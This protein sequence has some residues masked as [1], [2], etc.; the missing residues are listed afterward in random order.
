MN[1]SVLNL[2][3]GVQST[4]IYLMA[5]ENRRVLD[6]RAAAALPGGEGLSPFEPLPFPA[7]GEVNFAI[8]ADTQDEPEEVYRH[9]EWLQGL[10]GVPIFVRTKGR[11]SA[12]LRNGTN[13][14]GGRFASIPAFT[15]PD[16]PMGYTGPVEEG[17]LRRQCTKEYKLE[18]IDR[19]IRREI[20]NRRPRQRVPKDF[21]VRQIIG[22]S[23]D[24]KGRATRLY[25]RIHEEGIHWLELDF[26]LLTMNMAREHCVEW[27]EPRVPHKCPRSACVFCPFHDDLEWLRIKSNPRDWALAVEVDESL[28]IP[29]NVVNRNM[30][31]KLYLHR[32]C[33]PLVQIE[34][35]PTP[36]AKKAQKF[37]NFSNECL[38][39]CGV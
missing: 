9:V 15:A 18:V 19:T 32:S 1:V 17:R 34:F 23:Q 21:K 3:A 16:R 27:L 6:M 36:N 37:L 29:G 39:M 38:G 24:E 13:S 14:T 25:E 5:C 26:P 20:L 2:G 22:I 28:R 35:D 7:V 8:F 30:E 4:T 31:Q 33:Q 11:L 10:N 12:D